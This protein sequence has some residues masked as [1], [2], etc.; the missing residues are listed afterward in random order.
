MALVSGSVDLIVNKTKFEYGKKWLPKNDTFIV[1]ILG[2]NHQQFGSYDTSDRPGIDGHAT[3]P[4]V[5]QQ[6]ITISAILHVATRAG[7]LMSDNLD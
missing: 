2:G 4:E 1:D 5:L 7:F 6:E 3:I